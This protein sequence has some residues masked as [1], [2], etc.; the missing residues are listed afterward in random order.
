[1]PLGGYKGSGL[2]VMIEILCS[3]LS[4]GAMLTQM[5]GLWNSTSPMKVSQYFLAIDVGRFMPVEEFGARMQFV[6]ET[7]TGS[8]TA[9][10][11]DEVLIA[12][13]PEWRTESRRRVEGIPVPVAIWK[14]L[15]DL[16]SGLK[17]AAG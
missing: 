6:R 3:V 2:A 13:D 14:Q 11:Y 16:G 17:P 1:M 12:G 10:G 15:Q 4:G 5:G 7:V 8:R 9:A